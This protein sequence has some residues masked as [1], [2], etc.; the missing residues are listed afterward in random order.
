MITKSYH[1]C[2]RVLLLLAVILGIWAALWASPLVGLALFS[3]VLTLACIIKL[4]AHLNGKID[5]RIAKLHVQ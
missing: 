5:A 1:Q 4:F 2:A 3:L